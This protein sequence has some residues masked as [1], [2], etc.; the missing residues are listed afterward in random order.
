KQIDT[1]LTKV[2]DDTGSAKKIPEVTAKIPGQDTGGAKIPQTGTP[3]DEAKKHLGGHIQ[4]VPQGQDGKFSAAIG[5]VLAD[6]SALVRSYLQAET[7][8]RNFPSQLLWMYGIPEKGE[9][10]KSAKKYLPLYAIK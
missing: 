4:F 10:R 8:R 3:E 9:K 1:A 6:D 5:Y 7:V 2:P